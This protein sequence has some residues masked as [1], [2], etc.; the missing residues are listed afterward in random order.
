MK[1]LE[2][3]SRHTSLGS[4]VRAAGIDLSYNEKLAREDIA[5][6]DC[7]CP[8]NS[9]QPVADAFVVDDGM[10]GEKELSVWYVLD[11]GK[12]GILLNKYTPFHGCLHDGG[13]SF[14]ILDGDQIKITN[15]LSKDRAVMIKHAK[16][17]TDMGPARVW[18]C[19]P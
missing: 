2:I 7:G 5:D 12:H 10:S 15:P 13:F 3:L 14:A 4:A 19:K 6:L 9:F 18:V 1:T 17:M 11:A 8:R 16:A